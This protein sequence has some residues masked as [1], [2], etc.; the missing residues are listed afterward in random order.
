M[1][2]KPVDQSPTP[3][4]LLFDLDGTVYSGDHA[5][6]GASEFF[7]ALDLP[8]LFV[9]N[10]GNRTPGQVCDQLVSMGVQCKPE[11]VLTSSQVVPLVLSAGSRVFCIGE[12]G[13]VDELN[14][15]GMTIVTDASPVEAVVVSFDRAISYDKLTMAVRHILGGARFIATNDD[16]IITTPEGVLPEAGPIVAAVSNA[17]GKS[18][19]I[20]GKPH[21]P[22][23]TA[24]LER[25]GTYASEVILIGDNLLT[26]ILTGKNH[27][28]KTAL[29]LTGVSSATDVQELGIQPDWIIENYA[30]LSRLL[31]GLG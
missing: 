18:P 8:Y 12:Q 16:Q 2:V 9:T 27:G 11:N 29:I 17:T 25:M 5:I 19:E 15:V 28:L 10:R 31:S 7:A 20:V 3:K 23:V 30:H 4:A 26:D 13:L 22:I 21:K 6:P 14:A 24:A 1:S